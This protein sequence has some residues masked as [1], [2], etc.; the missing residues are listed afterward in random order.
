M[1][2]QIAVPVLSALTL[3]LS[4][5]GSMSMGG[6]WPFDSGP[7]ERSRAPANA[8]AYLCDGGKRLY[9]RYLDNGAHAWVILPEREFRLDKSPS[10]SGTR[11]GTGRASLEVNGN[12]VT[13]SDGPSVSYT[14]CKVP[15]PAKAGAV[16]ED[17]K[18]KDSKNDKNDTGDRKK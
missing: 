10:S 1:T 6:L 4:G 13:L 8:V 3:L 17:G 16:K 5:C 14:A 9:V 12:E 11:Y 18:L 2:I 7:E 15:E